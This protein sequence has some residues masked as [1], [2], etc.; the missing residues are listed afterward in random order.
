MGV[1]IVGDHHIM[2]SYGDCVLKHFVLLKHF[3]YGVGRFGDFTIHIGRQFRKFFSIVLSV[4][5]Y[6]NVG[7]PLQ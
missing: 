4:C 2:R 5:L 1:A 7:R 6:M 3:F